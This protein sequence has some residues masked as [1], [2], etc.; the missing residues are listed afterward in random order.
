MGFGQVMQLF[1]RAPQTFAPDAPPAEGDQRMGELVG[2][3]L[4]VGRVPGVEVGQDP[5]AP[6]VVKGDHQ[7]QGGQGHARDQEEHACVHPTQEEHAH[8]DGGDD[9]EG[10]HVGLTQQEQPGDQHRHGHG[11]HG[12]QELFP[13]VHLAHHVAGGVQR[14]GDLGEL[15]GLEVHDAQGNP[16][17]REV[18]HLADEGHQHDHQQHQGQHEEVAGVLF[19][20]AHGNAQRHRCHEAAHGQREGMPAEEMGGLVAR[21]LGAVGQ[22]DGGRIH[23]HQAQQGQAQRHGHQGAVVAPQT[24]HRRR[25]LAIETIAHRQVHRG[26][27]GAAAAQARPPAIQVQGGR[28]AHASSSPRAS[29]R[30]RTASTK[31]WARW[32]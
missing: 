17:A 13:C 27:V 14:D 3:A 29:A 1:Q 18:H 9:D 19:P 2:L 20:E 30:S 22:G 11:P 16:S 5:R 21:E 32:A 7:G 26:L 24:R 8:G 31:T 6:Q 28:Q 23:H 10:P 12:S 25:E 15:R 4:G